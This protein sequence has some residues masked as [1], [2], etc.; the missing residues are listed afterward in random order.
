MFPMFHY[1]GS[2]MAKLKY[3]PVRIT[4]GMKFHS[5][6]MCFRNHEFQRII[7]W[8]RR[9]ALLPGQPFTPGFNGGRE[10]SIA[11]RSHLNDHGIHAVALVH[12]ELA[13]EF[14]FL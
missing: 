12:V 10:K 14:I 5:S 6:F 1:D 4:P 3:S 13:N 9:F 11:G 7:K 2:I 8:N